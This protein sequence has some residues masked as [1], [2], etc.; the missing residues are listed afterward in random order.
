ME[1]EDKMSEKKFENKKETLPRREF[2][3]GAAFSASTAAVAAVSAIPA[4]AEA[5]CLKHSTDAGYR[6]TDH[7]STYYSLARF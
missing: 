2:L 1:V 7:V 3:K 6:E 5:E 4:T